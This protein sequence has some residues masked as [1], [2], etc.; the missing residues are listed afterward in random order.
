MR[1]VKYTQPLLIGMLVANGKTEPD[2]ELPMSSHNCEFWDLLLLF[3][4]KI[5][6]MN[7]ENL[8]SSSLNIANYFAVVSFLMPKGDSTYLVR[9]RLP[10]SFQF[11]KRP[12]LSVVSSVVSLKF[13]GVAVQ[14]AVQANTEQQCVLPMER[15]NISASQLLASLS[16]VVL[17]WFSSFLYTC[18]GICRKVTESWRVIGSHGSLSCASALKI[19]Y[20]RVPTSNVTSVYPTQS[21]RM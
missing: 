21:C 11:S 14:V 16:E 18:N 19:L 3:G 20:L 6:S 15:S 13:A 4:S 2:V 12:F 9:L 7:C 10:V 5:A 8:F 17:Q 1:T